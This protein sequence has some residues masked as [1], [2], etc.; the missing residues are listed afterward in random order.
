MCL[1]AGEAKKAK[2]EKLN[3]GEAPSSDEEDIVHEEKD[4]EDFDIHEAQRKEKVSEDEAD[5][6]ADDE[7]EPKKKKRKKVTMEDKTAVQ[8]GTKSRKK[9]TASGSKSVKAGKDTTE[10]TSSMKLGG[11]KAGA[12]KGLLA[13]TSS[14]GKA[15][16]K[17]AAT[18]ASKLIT[19]SSS[20]VKPAASKSRG[21]SL[22][23]K[24][25]K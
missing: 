8:G 2:Y 24:K 12:V 23:S 14:K 19:S 10:P 22:L 7:D 21:L 15:A 25:P 20:L 3:E 1:L 18:A 5:D 17:P 16:L 13:G 11:G 6:E 4:E 9:P